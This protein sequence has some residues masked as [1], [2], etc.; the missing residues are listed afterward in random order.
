MLVGDQAPLLNQEAGGDAQD[1]H[2]GDESKKGQLSGD[3]QA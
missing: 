3:A 1:T 2:A